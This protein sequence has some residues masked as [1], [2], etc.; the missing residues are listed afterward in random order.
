MSSIFISHSS[1]DNAT[2]ADLTAWLEKNGHRSVFLD[3]DPAKG[4]P[5]GRDWEKELYRN[6]RSCRAV[7]AISQPALDPVA[8]VLR[9][10][11]PR[12]GAGQ[13]RVSD[14]HRR[15][16]AR[17]SG[18]GYAD[19]RLPSGP[20][21]GPDA[22]RERAAGSGARFPPTRSI[23]T[24]RVR[25]IPAS[26]RFRKRTPRSS[27]DATP[28][29][30]TAS[31]SSTNRTALAIPPCCSCWVRQAAASH[32]Y[33][34]PGCSHASAGTPHAG[35]SCDPF[36]PRDDP[37]GELRLG[38]GARD[39]TPQSLESIRQALL[40]DTNA[41]E[42]HGAVPAVNQEP[43][44]A[45]PFL[46]ALTSAEAQLPAALRTQVAAALRALKAAA[47]AAVGP[48]SAGS[49]PAAL[50]GAGTRLNALL[51]S[52]RRARG[53]DDAS[54][55]LTIDQFEELLGHPSNHPCSAFTRLLGAS[56]HPAGS[57]K[58]VA[59]MRSDFLGQF[60]QAPALAGLRH[61]TLSVGPLSAGDIEAVITRPP[62]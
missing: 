54:V 5:A 12:P 33:C 23:G 48:A 10:A 40:E 55:L 53:A 29:S 52:L 18:P 41:A 50:I 6:I 39:G 46:Q 25:S 44:D 27:S 43:E 34:A 51:T 22:P 35:W 60:Q 31:T 49:A 47:A 3:F 36:R 14:P 26:S 61:E 30:A 32:R 1:R 2:A 19:C 20:G 11:D 37:A 4:I 38:A 7:V 21:R 8:V 58:L 9:G 13:A 56:L 17:W 57:L 45:A 28:M 24:R 15:H 62:T 59:T 42:A 16:H